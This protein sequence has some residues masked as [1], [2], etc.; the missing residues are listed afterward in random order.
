MEMQA[1][2]LSF[3][4]FLEIKHVNLSSSSSSS[5][6]LAGWLAGI[7]SFKGPAHLVPNGRNSLR[8]LHRWLRKQIRNMC[9]QS[10]DWKQVCIP[11]QPRAQSFVRISQLQTPRRSRLFE[12]SSINRWIFK[13]SVQMAGPPQTSPVICRSLL[14]LKDWGQDW[15]SQIPISDHSSIP[16]Q[17]RDLSDREIRLDTKSK[18]LSES[19]HLKDGFVDKRPD[20]YSEA[21]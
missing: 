9:I 14:V 18:C 15:K 21:N 5:D 8:D 4:G 17:I 20:A 11:T 2:E 7:A 1:Q 3:W 13:T 10:Q 12:C 16:I 6:W 19:K